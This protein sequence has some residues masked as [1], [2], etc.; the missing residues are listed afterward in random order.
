MDKNDYISKAEL[1]DRS[2]TIMYILSM[3]PKM[4]ILEALEKVD[5]PEFLESLLLEEGETQC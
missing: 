2:A 5:D 4:T 1:E 3:R